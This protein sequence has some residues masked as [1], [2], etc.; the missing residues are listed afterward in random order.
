MILFAV[1]VYSAVHYELNLR[2]AIASET[3]L[4]TLM[5]GFFTM[6]FS[7]SKIKNETIQ[8]IL[9]LVILACN[10]LI[11]FLLLYGTSLL[12]N[13]AITLVY[14]AIGTYIGVATIKAVSEDKC[15]KCPNKTTTTR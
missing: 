3:V 10:L 13:L 15:E 11:F 7:K 5:P 6:L 4:K 1:V 8:T 12:L 14:V 2:N 9:L